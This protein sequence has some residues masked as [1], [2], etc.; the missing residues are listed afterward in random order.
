M[1]YEDDLLQLD[2]P[3]SCMNLPQYMYEC[4]VLEHK[5][6][7]GML[8][9][10]GYLVRSE[11]GLIYL[12]EEEKK[13][14]EQTKSGGLTGVIREI[15]NRF[16]EAIR[17]IADGYIKAAEA[18]IGKTKA[19]IDEEVLK[20]PKAAQCDIKDIWYKDYYD[21]CSEVF[22]TDKIDEL[23][24]ENADYKDDINLIMKN[25]DDK[26]KKI[27]TT[28]DE[29][30]NKDKFTQDSLAKVVSLGSKK[31]VMRELSTVLTLQ[32]FMKK[33]KNL[34]TRFDRFNEQA[35]KR[36]NGST[37]EK[38]DEKELEKRVQKA[39]QAR[40]KYMNTIDHVCMK[41]Q[42]IAWRNYNE[43]KAFVRGSDEKKVENDQGKTVEQNNKNQN[44]KNQ[45]NKNNNQKNNKPGRIENN[46]GKTVEQNGGKKGTQESY[47]LAQDPYYVGIGA[48]LLFESIFE[49]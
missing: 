43:I 36:I 41:T 17:N 34:Q 48:D 14:V 16:R 1:F 21:A 3:R 13:E 26:I 29:F 30:D 11:C 28:I 46:Q 9:L 39:T 15:F 35:V 37:D 33:I 47:T 19:A 45:N 5:F 27:P 22:K 38:I 40:L 20:S 7:E 12:S 42:Q 24:A 6:F 4:A 10:D 32:D 49:I 44:N 18:F 8:K 31:G 25:C 2:K 23:F